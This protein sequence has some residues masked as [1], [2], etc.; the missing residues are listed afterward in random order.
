MAK[1]KIK[2]EPGKKTIDELQKEAQE[3]GMSYGQYV[4]MLER[5]ARNNAE[6]SRHDN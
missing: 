4:A 3:H 6:H 1:R 5:K 2:K